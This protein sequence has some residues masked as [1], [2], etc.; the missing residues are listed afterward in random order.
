MRR[1]CLMLIL[2]P[3]IVGCARHTLTVT[4]DPPGALV[5]LN[6]QEIGRTP[7]TRDFMWYGTYD[8]QLRLAG[9]ETVKTKARLVAPP[10]FWPP[11]DLAGETLPLRDDRR[12]SYSLKPHSDQSADVTQMLQRSGQLRIQ[13]ESSTHVPATQPA[14]KNP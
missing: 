11:L 12:L 2:L 8:V 1:Y 5:F 10:W 14:D 4:S 6:D 7:V 13:L 3:L 9:Y